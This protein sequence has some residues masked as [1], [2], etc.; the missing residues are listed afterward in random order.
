MNRSQ[1]NAAVFVFVC[2]TNTCA[3]FFRFISSAFQV[4]VYASWCK[5]CQVFDVRFRGLAAKYG[6]NSDS[7]RDGRVR[8]AEMQ[9]DN[10]NNEEL[11]Q[12]LNATKLPYIL[13]YKGSK[14]K[15]KEF[16]CSPA[17]FQLLI[18]AVNELGDDLASTDTQ[19]IPEVID[20]VVNSDVAMSI[21]SNAEEDTISLQ[22]QLE[23]DTVEKLALFEV[24]EAQS[25]SDKEYIQKLE[26][27]ITAQ[28]STLDAKDI[29]LLSLQ[30]S[31]E[32]EMQSL[33]NELTR[34]Q[35]ESN[36]LKADIS[37][38]QIQ[39]HQLN[40]RISELEYS[41]TSLELESSFNKNLAKDKEHQLQLSA[42]KLEEQKNYYEKERSSLRKLALLGM[43]R[44][45][46][47]PR[48][49]FLRFKGKEDS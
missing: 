44:V 23:R 41:I 1:C 25:E 21:E 20:N 32:K 49:L 18:D 46:S 11:C 33:S 22:Q 30:K 38:Y 15:V 42:D 10:P 39:V 13:M 27:N 48:S 2:T 26:R 8:F 4:K 35:D 7:T 3:N 28:Q 45:V 17:K 29:E 6:D 14:G 5:T 47:G 24:M 12:L 9:Y 36:Q 34:Q 43:K 40:Q 16:H 31:Y 19:L 37:A